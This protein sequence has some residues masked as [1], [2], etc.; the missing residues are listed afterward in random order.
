MTDKWTERLSEYIDGGLTREENEALEAHLMTCADCGRTVAE[1]RAVVARAGQV[2]DR[3]PENDLWPG[4]ASRIAETPDTVD[5]VTPHTRRRFSFSMPQLAA[6]SVVLVLLSSGTV[7]M[8]MQRNAQPIAQA[9]AT[10]QQRGTVIPA[11]TTAENYDTAIEELERTLAS[12]RS[13][14]DTATVRV[15]EKNLRTIDVA[16]AEARQALGRDPGNTYLNRYLDKTM[17]R[18]VQLLRRA[19]RI[20]RAHT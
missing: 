10:T 1:L 8:M 13:E 19:T 12:G 14:L 18:K 9:P 16:I 11:N 5:T 7:F 2:I 20:L 4:V 17:Q 3:P 15:L 6:A